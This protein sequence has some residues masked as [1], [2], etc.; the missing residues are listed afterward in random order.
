MSRFWAMD[1]LS[2]MA[3]P[4][5]SFSYGSLFKMLTTSLDLLEKS[6]IDG[7]KKRF[8]N[9]KFIIWTSQ[10]YSYWSSNLLSNCFF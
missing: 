9:P 3:N 4:V 8:I 6:F 10:I 1:K 7:L 2:N 5:P